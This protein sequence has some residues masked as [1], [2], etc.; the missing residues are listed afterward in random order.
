M[1]LTKSKLKQI[2]KEELEVQTDA[3]HGGV[4][5]RHGGVGD[6]KYSVTISQG[7]ESISASLEDWLEAIEE[8][9]H[10]IQNAERE[11]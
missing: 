5:R 7:E 10:E 1:K 3:Y 4:F 11:Y 6:G 2:I 9:E 8:A